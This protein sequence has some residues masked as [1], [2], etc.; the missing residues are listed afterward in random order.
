MLPNMHDY[1]RG[2]DTLTW[3]QFKSIFDI[4]GKG[5]VMKKPGGKDLVFI[6]NTLN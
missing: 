4:A 5:L 3:H 1:L 2:C 6:H